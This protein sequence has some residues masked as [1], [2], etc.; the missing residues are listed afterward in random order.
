MNA[1]D[2][3][4]VSA[5]KTA[6]SNAKASCDAWLALS[7]TGSNGKFVDVKINPLESV[8][9]GRS[10]YIPTR[11]SQI[12]VALGNIT[13][14]AAGEYSGV[15]HY[16]Q[17]FKCMNYIIN[18]A[19]GPLY[20]IYTIGQAKNIA[21]K[22]VAN[23]VDKVATY[24]NV[25]RYSDFKEDSTGTNVIKVNQPQ[26]FSMSDSV[27]ITGENLSSFNATIT[28]ISGSSITLNKTVPT[29]YKKEAK[30]GIIKEL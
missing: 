19:N 27:L 14:N 25:V 10:S 29:A 6:A 28:N 5:A 23:G 9:N 17:R 7:N 18:G 22:K 13:Q 16:L 26:L 8:F 15:G 12:V 11:V 2:A 24:S 4:Q 3:A 20:Q 30:A 21:D 1:A